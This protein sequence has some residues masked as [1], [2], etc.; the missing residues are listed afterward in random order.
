[1]S[2]QAD[3]ALDTPVVAVAARLA[4]S[5]AARE[6]L[7]FVGAQHCCAPSRQDV[8]CKHSCSGRLRGSDSDHNLDHRRRPQR[9]RRQENLCARTS[10][11][12]FH[13][14]HSHNPTLNAS[15]LPEIRYRQFPIVGRSPCPSSGSMDD[16]LGPFPRVE[17][18]VRV[19]NIS[20]PLCS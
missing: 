7:R 5:I 17:L 13:A 6:F 19:V 8:K 11:Q 15:H 2:C 12:I 20:T 14:I 3:L 4:I 16:P 18:K 1:M 10:L 9:P